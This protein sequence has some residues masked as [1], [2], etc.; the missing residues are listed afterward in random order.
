MTLL[1]AAAAAFELEPLTTI[2]T[3]RRLDFKVFT[4]GIGALEAARNANA[5]AAS[6][7]NKDVWFLGSCGIFAGFNGV[8]VVE[9]RS[10]SWLPYGL[11]TG[12]S[13]KI[14]GSMP[15]IPL[16]SAAISQTG[17]KVDMLCSTTISLDPFLPVG[18]DPKGYAEN[19][20]LYSIT[21]PVMETCRSFRAIFGVTNAVGRDAHRQWQANYREAAQACAYFIGNQLGQC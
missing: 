17:K 1:I 14:A 3:A 11:R 4:V 15:S 21:G 16:P 6:A 7:A 9:A 5:L 10:V 12:K 8:E 20:E 19:I 2:L 18:Y 13:Y